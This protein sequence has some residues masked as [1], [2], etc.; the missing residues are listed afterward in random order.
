MDLLTRAVTED[1]LEAVAFA[2]AHLV[3]PK[4]VRAQVQGALDRAARELAARLGSSTG[5]ARARGLLRA[6]FREDGLHTPET[7]ADDPALN[8]LGRVLERRRGSPA[9]LAV[10][11]ARLGSRLD[12]A[13]TPV[14]FPGHFLVR[15][16]WGADAPLADPCTGAM[17]IDEAALRTLATRELGLRGAALDAA[18]APASA[19]TVAARLLQNVQRAA[20]RSAPALYKRAEAELTGLGAQGAIARRTLSLLVAS[21]RPRGAPEPSMRRRLDVDRRGLSFSVDGAPPV[22][23]SRRRALPLLLA[24]LAA[25]HRAGASHGLG[26]TALVEAGWPGEKI[27]ADAA[28][29][30]VRTSIRTL[31]KLG[32]EGLLVTIGSGYLIDPE[33]EV[34]WR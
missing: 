4:T 31:R 18:L 33:C 14:A 19:R 27:Q 10:L 20:E 12:V 28:W 8:H 7:Y 26:W 17:P 5:A 13:F 11:L 34:R 2:I 21:Y 29:S 30:R 3:E 1:D 23:L 22:D 32:L 6:L 9:A 25:H 24:H 16:G 15:V